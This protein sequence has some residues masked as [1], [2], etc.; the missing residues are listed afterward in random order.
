M[1]KGKPSWSKTSILFVEMLAQNFEFEVQNDV[2][3]R[4]KKK[5]KQTNPEWTNPC[6]SLFIKYIVILHW[7]WFCFPSFF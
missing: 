7:F 2:L 5:E 3:A 1:D 6:F 4:R